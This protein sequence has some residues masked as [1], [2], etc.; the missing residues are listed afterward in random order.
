LL[1]YIMAGYVPQR[2]SFPT[3]IGAVAIVAEDGRPLPTAQTLTAGA[4]VT[5]VSAE[6]Y[7]FIIRP[8]IAGSY[9]VDIAFFNYRTV[10]GALRQIGSIRS[11]IQVV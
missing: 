4:S 11:M 1:R 8:T 5:M 9:P 6:R 3:G 2:I 7:D 10:S